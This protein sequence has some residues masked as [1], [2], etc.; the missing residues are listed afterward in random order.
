MHVQFQDLSQIWK[1]SR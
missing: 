1:W